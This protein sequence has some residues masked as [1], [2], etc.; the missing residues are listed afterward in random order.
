MI[1]FIS[2]PPP[3]LVIL[4][5]LMPG[6]V[7]G[8][9]NLISKLAIALIWKTPTRLKFGKTK[10]CQEQN[11]LT[12]VYNKTGADSSEW[13]DPA[14]DAT[15]TRHRNPTHGHGRKQ[16]HRQAKTSK[17]GPSNR[18][19]PRPKPRPVVITG[20]VYIIH[21]NPCLNS[22]PRFGK[23]GS[24]RRSANYC[25]ARVRELQ[26]GNPH[27]L[28]CNYMFNVVGNLT[29]A[30]RTVHD[31]LRDVDGLN[32]RANHNC[33]GGREWYSFPGN[34]VQSL[35][36][37]VRAILQQAGFL[38]P[39]NDWVES[40][41]NPSLSP[42]Q[43]PQSVYNSKW[44]QVPCKGDELQHITYNCKWHFSEVTCVT[45]ARSRKWSIKCRYSNKRRTLTENN[46]ISAAL[47]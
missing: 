6:R 24:S 44:R 34:G 20:V 38:A 40:S 5:S 42:N 10:I 1:F 25:Q 16:P 31:T 7:K 41:I 8:A 43:S 37:R 15:A 18:V 28:V 21:M 23:V 11:I 36:Q 33:N 27:E 45:I 22:A 9:W 32:T 30:E 29:T 35:A 26:T 47:E 13:F 39:T 2:P 46:F 19:Q 17:P 12:F 3:P 14:E 4:S